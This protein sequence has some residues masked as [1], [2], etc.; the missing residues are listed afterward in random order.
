MMKCLRYMFAAL[1]ALSLASHASAAVPCWDA[2]TIGAARISEF[3]TLMMVS[4]LRC[5]SAGI[6]MRPDLDRFQTVQRGILEKAHEALRTRYGVARLKQGNNDYDRF[7][8][9]VANAYGMGQTA[10]GVCQ[11]VGALL[12]ELAKAET[13]A[14]ML[15][16][17]V[18]EMVR[19]PHLD[20]ERCVPGVLAQK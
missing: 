7:I 1:S 17:A 5:K 8:T 6:D 20:A 18:I 16:N 15:A 14:D 3:E 9:M 13:G 19:D 10:A 4:V 2:P 11:Q 12:T